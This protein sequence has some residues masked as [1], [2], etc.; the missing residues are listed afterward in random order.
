MF[1]K[2]IYILVASIIFFFLVINLIYKIKPSIFLSDDQKS[3]NEWFDSMINE[4]Q[5]SPAY[6]DQANKKN[7][8]EEE[9]VKKACNFFADAGKIE[10]IYQYDDNYRLIQPCCD[11]IDYYMNKNGFIYGIGGGM[12]RALNFSDIFKNIL[13]KIIVFDK[14]TKIKNINLI[15]NCDSVPL[16]CSYS[17]GGEYYERCLEI[18]N[19]QEKQQSIKKEEIIKIN[20]SFFKDKENVYVGN[21]F[22]IIKNANPNTFQPIPILNSS[23]LN[24]HNTEGTYGKDNINVFYFTDVIIGANPETFIPINH[25]F[26]KDSFSIFYQTKKIKEADVNSFFVLSNSYGS[27]S[28][29]YGKDK[30]HVFFRNLLLKDADY[31]SFEMCNSSG[32]AK[33]KNHVYLWGVIKEEF[34][35]NACE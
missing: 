11:G 19:Q 31:S 10:K 26:S 4:G 24:I 13:K 1:K 17:K 34:D 7:L 2:S 15:K 16:D 28:S 29:S 23:D 30:Y 12:P 22:K 3:I 14:K 25:S 35:L 9:I 6:I 27:D 8:S 33:D 32:Y 5:I 21:N 20:D 18:V